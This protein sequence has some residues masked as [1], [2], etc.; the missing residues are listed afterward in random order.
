LLRR[1]RSDRVALAAGIGLVLLVT[2]LT[3]GEPVIE[4]LVGHGHAETFPYAVEQGTQRPAGPWS[5]VP[6]VHEKRFAPNGAALPPARGTPQTLL[7]LGADGRLGRDEL[8]R[9]LV[10]GRTSL[11]IALGGTLIALG[12]GALIGVAAAYFGGWI[13]ATVERV[14]EV[15]A[16]FPL[17]LLVVVLGQT[18]ISDRLD[19]VTVGGLLGQGVLTVMLLIGIFTWF[20]SARVV[21][22][23]IISLR[24]R[25]FVEAARMVGA[26]DVRIIRSHLMPHVFPTLATIGLVAVG[27]NIVLEA[28]ITFFGFGVTS[29]TISWG[30]MI[31]D[32][33]SGTVFGTGGLGAPAADPSKTV[34][35]TLFPC[36]AIFISVLLANLLADALRDPTD[37]VAG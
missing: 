5:H 17:L 33:W 18:S 20:Y 22:A 7:I 8:L 19:R 9:L 32:T 6:D 25:E 14:T 10:G 1:I 2:L 28:G 35:L 29:P 13:D 31:S 4:R 26:G 30:T 11:L 15:V 12:L 16:A 3:V 37:P 23:E 34:W 21:R 27:T 24:E 36:L